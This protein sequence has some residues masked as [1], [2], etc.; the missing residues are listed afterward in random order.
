M[1]A[2]CVPFVRHF[3]LDSLWLKIATTRCRVFLSLH[4]YLCDTGS[5][6]SAVA[7]S[8]RFVVYPDSSKLKCII[9]NDVIVILNLITM[10]KEKRNSLRNCIR[11]HT[12]FENIRPNCFFRMCII[13]PSIRSNVLNKPFG[14]G[15]FI[16]Y[17]IILFVGFPMH[18]A[19]LPFARRSQCH[20]QPYQRQPG[21]TG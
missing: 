5:T 7:L 2:L 13:H 20:R 4:Y 21:R 10:H 17:L 16:T 19:E 18:D 12:K 15:G 3:L 8:L 11:S 14:G 6:T 9:I 1:I